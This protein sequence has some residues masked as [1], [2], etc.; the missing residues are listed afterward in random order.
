ME[1]N[2]VNAGSLYGLCH[3]YVLFFKSMV[4]Q[5]QISVYPVKLCIMYAAH[6]SSYSHRLCLWPLPLSPRNVICN[7]IHIFMFIIISFRCQVENS[8]S[9][10]LSIQYHRV[11]YIMKL[12]LLV[13]QGT[14]I[15]LIILF[16]PFGF[17]TLRTFMQST[18]F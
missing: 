17:K 16:H 3:L 5:F 11:T 2:I 7:N 18:L 15:K 9:Q 13:H 12:F 6:K 4:L 10:V 8:E 1:P 14:Q